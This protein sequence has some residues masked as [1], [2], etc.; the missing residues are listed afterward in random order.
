[1]IRQGG[2]EGTEEKLR[3]IIKARDDYVVQ[4][5]KANERLREKNDALRDEV[6][7]LKEM[8]EISGAQ[9]RPGSSGGVA[10]LKGAVGQ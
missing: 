6:E 2:S 4:V 5:L 1:M 9:G 7:G 10:Q 8:I 3:S